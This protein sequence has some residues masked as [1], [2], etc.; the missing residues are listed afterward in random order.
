MAHLIEGTVG[1]IVCVGMWRGARGNRQCFFA[2]KNSSNKFEII[3][4]GKK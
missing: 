1:G 3:F 4:L 2:E